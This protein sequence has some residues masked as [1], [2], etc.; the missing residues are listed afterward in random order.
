MKEKLSGHEALGHEHP[1]CDSVQIAALILFTSIWIAGVFLPYL[2]MVKLVDAPLL[3]VPAI[4]F[5]AIGVH[6]LN[7]STKTIFGKVTVSHRLADRGVYSWVRHPMYLGVIMIFSGFFFLSPSVILLAITIAL[8]IAYDRMTVYEE[9]ELAKVLGKRYLE[10][11]KRV[12]KWFPTK[13]I[14]SKMRA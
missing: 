10:Y 2:V 13:A 14:A 7:Q 3:I 6:L 5:I 9:R 1:H 12:S 11:K 8:F 4:I